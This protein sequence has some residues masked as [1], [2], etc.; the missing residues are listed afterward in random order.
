VRRAEPPAQ[1][2]GAPVLTAA[3][4]LARVEAAR[5]GG[6]GAGA[7]AAGGRLPGGARNKVPLEKGYSQ[8]DWLRLTRSGGDLTGE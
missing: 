1:P 7:G 8:V 5:A 2:G 4:R 6:A 3:A